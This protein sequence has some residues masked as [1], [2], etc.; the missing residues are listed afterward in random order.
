[1]PV[2][3]LFVWGVGVGQSVFPYSASEA[4]TVSESWILRVSEQAHLFVVILNIFR[5]A[6]GT[7]LP[8]IQCVPGALFLG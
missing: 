4:A 5:T 1:V 2:W 3:F 7:T 8:P 6:L